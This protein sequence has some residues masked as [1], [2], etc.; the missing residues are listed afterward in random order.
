MLVFSCYG[1]VTTKKL[2]NQGAARSP[3]PAIPAC[4]MMSPAAERRSGRQ[5]LSK[6]AR[7]LFA[8][9]L[10]ALPQRKKG[11][12]ALE[13]GGL[14]TVVADAGGPRV[15]IRLPP[16]GIEVEDALIISEQVEL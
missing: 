13:R 5:V 9:F 1:S 8:E 11:D 12:E 10:I 3:A 2:G 14:E 15:R 16:A 6:D 4:T 7:T